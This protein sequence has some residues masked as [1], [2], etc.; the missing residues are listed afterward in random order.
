MY[1]YIYTYTYRLIYLLTHLPSLPCACCSYSA[2]KL[3]K[4]E[5]AKADKYFS[6]GDWYRR[7]S[8]T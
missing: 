2:T 7:E 8:I 5:V 3:S 1:I 4:G 6:T